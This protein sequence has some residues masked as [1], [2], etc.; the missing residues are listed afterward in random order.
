MR[1]GLAIAPCVPELGQIR[2]LNSGEYRRL[3]RVGPG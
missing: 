2:R 1:G 3:V